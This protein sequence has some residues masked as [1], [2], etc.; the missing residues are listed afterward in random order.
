MSFSQ[1]VTLIIWFIVSNSLAF[2]CGMKYLETKIETRP[3]EW[4]NVSLKK[5]SITVEQSSDHIDLWVNGVKRQPG[6]KYEL[7]QK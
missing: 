4:I 7:D 6:E 3:R 2:Y 1:K 5:S